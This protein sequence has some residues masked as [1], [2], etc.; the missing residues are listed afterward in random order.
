MQ[1]RPGWAYRFAGESG[2][3]HVRHAAG[4]A[5]PPDGRSS[6]MRRMHVHPWLARPTVTVVLYRGWHVHVHVQAPAALAALNPQTAARPPS[7][8]GGRQAQHA[9]VGGGSASCCGSGLLPCPGQH[10]RTAWGRAL[11]LCPCKP[12]PPHC[13]WWPAAPAGTAPVGSPAPAAAPACCPSRRAGRRRLR[14]RGAPRRLQAAPPAQARALRATGLRA[15]GGAGGRAVRAHE[16]RLCRLQVH[17]WSAPQAAGA[18][19]SPTGDPSASWLPSLSSC[20]VQG[21]Q[22]RQVCRKGPRG[23]CSRCLQAGRGA[24]LP[25]P[26]APQHAE[27]QPR[28]RQPPPAASHTQPDPAGTQGKNNP[29][30]PKRQGNPRSWGFHAPAGR[31]AP[32]PWTQSAARCL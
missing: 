9:S 24:P 1:L 2:R 7:A 17:A 11:A 6:A 29:A 19:A 26:P 23:L 4:V 5:P 14:P 25:P 12:A 21:A 16:R 13:R 20:E 18:A 8:G 27:A 32:R 31:A 28:R 10:P 30:A 15:G 22:G 3:W